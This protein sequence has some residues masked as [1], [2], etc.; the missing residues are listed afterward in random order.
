MDVELKC[1]I[2][3]SGFVEEMDARGGDDD[4][5]DDLRSDRAFSLWAPML[6]GKMGGWSSRR[7]PLFPR[8][9]VKKQG[10]ADSDVERSDFNCLLMRRRSVTPIPRILL[11]LL[12]ST[13]L[14]YFF[15][16]NFFY[17]ISNQP[18]E[19]ARLFQKANTVFLSGLDVKRK[20]LLTSSCFNFRSYKT[21]NTE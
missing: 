3:D 8:V 4:P 17:T 1:P 10:R 18:A 21:T 7:R 6:L 2:C 12:E 5:V 14:P 15:F 16:L 9:Q 13:P 11:L 19:S 20:T